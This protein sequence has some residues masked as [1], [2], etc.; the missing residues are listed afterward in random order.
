MGLEFSEAENP[1]SGKHQ[2]LGLIPSRAKQKQ[3]P[4]ATD[5]REQREQAAQTAK[6]SNR[7]QRRGREEAEE[8]PHKW[9]AQRSVL[10]AGVSL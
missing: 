4:T 2:D 1:L 9:K 7:R 3:T 6:P 5:S 8:R 10:L